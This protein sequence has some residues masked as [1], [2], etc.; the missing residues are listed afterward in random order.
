MRQLVGF[1]IAVRETDFLLRFE[2]EAGEGVEFAC[3]P[4][5][6][7]LMIDALDQLLSQDDD[8]FAVDE[9]DQAAPA[10]PS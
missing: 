5:Q 10:K 4:E 9:A 6:L 1:D 7:D 3:S 8:A 2:D